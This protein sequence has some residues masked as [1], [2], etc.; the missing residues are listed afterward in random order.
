MIAT[1]SVFVRCHTK[2]CSF[3]DSGRLRR[4]VA[5]LIVRYRIVGME[6]HQHGLP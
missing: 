3:V 6:M 5:A 4:H 1:S 2:C